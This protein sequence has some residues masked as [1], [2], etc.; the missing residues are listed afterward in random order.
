M[1]IPGFREFDWMQDMWLELDRMQR[2]VGRLFS[3][4]SIPYS[5]RF[6]AINIWSKD[7]EALVTAEIPGVVPENIDISVEGDVLTLSGSRVPEELGEKESYHRQERPHGTFKRN[8]RLPF[9]VDGNKVKASYEKGVLNI[10]LPRLE[11]DKPRK[12]VIKSE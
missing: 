1:L 10:S 4:T 2:E 12:I 6:P 3:G 9:R 7:D 8:V 5:Q 11:E